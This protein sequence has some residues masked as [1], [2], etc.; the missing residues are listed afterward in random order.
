MSNSHR[1]NAAE[2][3]QKS[4]DDS[5]DAPTRQELYERLE[6]VALTEER[7][8]RRRLSKARAQK[9]LAAIGV[10]IDK[11]ASR[12]ELIDAHVPELEYPE[13]LPVTDRKEA[14]EKN[15]CG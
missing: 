9:A 12:V 14:F 3:S 4:Q 5:I 8:F 6:R 1:D 2:N 7:S 11:A 15:N 13:A 10:D